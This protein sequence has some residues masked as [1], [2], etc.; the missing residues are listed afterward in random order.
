[1]PAPSPLFTALLRTDPSAPQALRSFDALVAGNAPAPDFYEWSARIEERLLPSRLTYYFDVGRH[2]SGVASA[3]GERFLAL[4]RTLDVPLSS[5]LDSLLRSDLPSRDEILQ[6]V[7]G[8]DERDDPLLRRLKYY[9]V[10]R[11]QPRRSVE[12]VLRAAEMPCPSS[13]DPSRTYILGLDL[14]PSGVD[15]CKLYFRLD[16]ARAPGHVDNAR[17]LGPLLRGT[18]D[19]VMQC[20]LRRPERRQLYLHATNDHVIRNWLA[21]AAPARP[22]I[23][24]LMDRARA[25]NQ[26][27][28]G[29]R[30]D[31]WIISFAYR[32]RRLDASAMNVYFHIRE[33]PGSRHG[34]AP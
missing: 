11:A 7:I 31:P 28:D 4:C 3:A 8:I 13:I 9:L 25:I 33:Q 34:S 21:E 10:F 20:C 29:F 32:D 22:P 17:E 5:A 26:G 2:G 1:M 18:R 16:P 12:A 6:I 14:G 24:E 27:P 30:I 19:F 23:G 15:D